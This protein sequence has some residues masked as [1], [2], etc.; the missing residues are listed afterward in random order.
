LRKQLVALLL[1]TIWINGVA[2]WVLTSTPFLEWPEKTLKILI[3]SIP[4]LSFGGV[5]FWWFGKVK[6]K[7]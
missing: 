2:L 7:Q 3:Y 5:A 4:A 6:D 1:A